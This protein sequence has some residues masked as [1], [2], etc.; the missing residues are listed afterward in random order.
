V[1]D[2]RVG[3]LTYTRDDV[4]HAL[5]AVEPYDWAAF[6]DK[7]L[8]GV[9]QPAPLDGLR[10]GGYRLIYTDTPSAF[11]KEG[12]AKRKHADLS[13]SL[14]LAIADKDG[15]LASVVWDSPAFK[16]G[17]TEGEQM[18]A[19]NGI[20]YNSDVLSDAVRA[21]RAGTAPIELILKSGDRFI[22]AR[23]EYTGGLR[24][25][26][27]EKVSDGPALLDAILTARRN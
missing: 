17:L 16:A 5:N 23:L 20:A 25:P 21:A 13:Y 8:D 7:R 18:L 22:V 10:R 6:L 2:G 15:T 1:Q 27:L 4:I 12:D 3:V 19:V 11:Q 14:G 24:Y 26:H 9:G